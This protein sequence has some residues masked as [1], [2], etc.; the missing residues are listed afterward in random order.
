MESNR[1][2]NLITDLDNQEEEVSLNSNCKV[3]S[4][5]VNTFTTNTLMIDT[6]FQVNWIII[7]SNLDNF[8]PTN[9]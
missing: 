2:P 6:E 8:L 5:R 3:L 9:S 1:N 7:L 4:T